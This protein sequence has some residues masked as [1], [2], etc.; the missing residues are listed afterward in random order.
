MKINAEKI[1]EKDLK[2]I[3]LDIKRV[4]SANN[5]NK[6]NENILMNALKVYTFSTPDVGY[7][8]AMSDLVTPFIFVFDNLDF[9]E[10]LLFFCIQNFID[11]QKKNLLGQQEGT[12][13]LIEQLKIFLKKS[14][15]KLYKDLIITKK[16]DLNIFSFRWFNCCFVREFN[17]E[18]YLIILDTLLTTDDYRKF[19]VCLAVYILKK[20]KHH[21][22]ELSEFEIIKFLQEMKNIKWRIDELLELFSF[23]YMDTLKY[24]NFMK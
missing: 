10:P 16:V 1:D 19:C 21:I 23:V 13:E 6:K 15:P 18:V 7:V 3:K 4:S 12:N 20:Y 24:D 22:L 9:S 5:I 2:Q 14:D 8:Q 17:I 11:N